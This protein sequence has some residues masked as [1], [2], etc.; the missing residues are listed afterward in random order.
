M[1]QIIHSNQVIIFEIFLQESSELR[2]ACRKHLKRH[3]T[4]KDG[5]LF[6]EGTVLFDS[7]EPMVF[8]GMIATSRLFMSSEQ[9]LNL[10]KV[11][12][13]VSATH[14]KN[15]Q[16]IQEIR[17]LKKRFRQL[18]INSADTFDRYWNVTHLHKDLSDNRY[19]RQYNISHSC[20]GPLEHAQVCMYLEELSQILGIFTERFINPIL[21]ANDQKTTVDYYE[22]VFTSS[23]S[24]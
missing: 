12:N 15:A 13:I 3:V 19:A 8:R 9:T 11:A 20:M 5:M 7:V 10:I 16:L 6:E 4:G 2:A 24:L 17:D 23:G 21:I 18:V 22:S 14:K 1:S